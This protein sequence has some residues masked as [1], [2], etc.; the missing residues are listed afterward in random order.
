MVAVAVA[1]DGT[2]APE[3]DIHIAPLLWETLDGVLV[4]VATKAEAT[5]K[6]AGGTST[7]VLAPGD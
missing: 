2:I 3:G 4:G 5:T 7:K 1:V 6:G